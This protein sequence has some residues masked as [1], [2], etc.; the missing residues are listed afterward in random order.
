MSR[1]NVA[2]NYTTYVANAD[3]DPIATGKLELLAL[4]VDSAEVGA[5]IELFDAD[6][7]SLGIKLDLDVQG[8]IDYKIALAN[9]L[10]ATI[11]GSS[12]IRV[13]V[14]YKKQDVY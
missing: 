10:T 11:T 5:A 2:S 3:L 1:D 4:V 7:V 9:G 13:H 8:R 12:S 14:L 6:E